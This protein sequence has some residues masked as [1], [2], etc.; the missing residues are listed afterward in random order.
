MQQWPDHDS[1]EYHEAGQFAWTLFF[2]QL[3]GLLRGLLPIAL[4][5]IGLSFSWWVCKMSAWCAGFAWG[6]TLKGYHLFIEPIVQM[7]LHLFGGK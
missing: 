6:Y 1:E 4:L 7:V 2:Q 5:S 3:P